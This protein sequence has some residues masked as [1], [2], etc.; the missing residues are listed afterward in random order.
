MSILRFIQKVAV[1]TAVYWGNPVDDHF[2]GATFD[3]PTELAPP[4]NGVRWEDR[5]K[6]IISKDGKELVVDVEVLVN[7]DLDIGGWLY[8]GTFDDL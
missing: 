1:Q 2:G 3:D 4:T 7:Q 5:Q 8:L 6:V